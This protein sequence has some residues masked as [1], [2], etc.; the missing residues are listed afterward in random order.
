M[1]DIEISNGLKEMFENLSKEAIYRHDEDK[2]LFKYVSINT[3]KMIIGNGTLKF[4]TPEELNDNDL[5][6]TLLD[7]SVTV[8]TK[9]KVF[10]KIIR[11]NL[12]PA[13]AEFLEHLTIPNSTTIIPDDEFVKMLS[14]GYLN[15]RKKFGLLCLTTDNENDFMWEKYAENHRGVCM[16]FKFPTLYNKLFYTFTINYGSTKPFKYFNEDGSVN[17]LAVNRWLFTKDKIY[18]RE[19]E[20]RLLSENNLGIHPFPKKNLIGIHFGKLTSEDDIIDGK[21]AE[22]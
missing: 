13:L 12:D 20:V 8:A 1:Q 17:S 9:K 4:S 18:S 21:R 14:Y 10:S 3:A 2:P 7:F 19:K 11:K 15:E 6:I 5:D 22:Y 16:E